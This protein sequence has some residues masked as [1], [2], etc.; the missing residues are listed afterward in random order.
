MANIIYQLQ[1]SEWPFVILPLVNIVEIA[2]LDIIAMLEQL[3][4]ASSA[5][6]GSNL[7]VIEIQISIHFSLS[8][9][10]NNCL[11]QIGHLAHTLVFLVF[12]V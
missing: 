1:I 12:S 6:F 7:W 5:L 3:N 10:M 11:I 8:L 4:M 2:L 9:L